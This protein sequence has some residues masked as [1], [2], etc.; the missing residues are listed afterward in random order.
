MTPPNFSSSDSAEPF[1][2][3]LQ[4]LLITLEARELGLRRRAEAVANL[5]EP[6]GAAMQLDSATMQTLRHGALVHDIGNIGI[7]DA[8][9]LKPTGLSDWEFQEIRLHPIIGERIL[10]P[11]RAFE[12]V[13]PLVRS[14]HERL[15]GSGYPNRLKG[16]AIPML[17]RI[18]SVAD[19]YQTLR[20]K[21]AYRPAFSHAQALEILGSEV[22]R[23]WWDAQVVG[24]LQS[25]PEPVIP[26]VDAF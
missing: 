9:L 2:A 7:P 25:L 23:G 26:T 13:R 4:S 14:H 1:E 19:V 18:L 24:I 22:E 12:S 8:I 15:D 3:V 16:E 10:Q 5:C 21:R 6:I 17:V 11:L 20:A